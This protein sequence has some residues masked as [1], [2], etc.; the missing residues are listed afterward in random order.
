MLVRSARG[1]KILMLVSG[2]LFITVL[3]F[4][5]GLGFFI[6]TTVKA[7]NVSWVGGADLDW[8]TPAN[9]SSF[10]DLPTAL[11]DVRVSSAASLDVTTSGCGAGQVNFSTLTIGDGINANTLALSNGVIGSGGSIIVKNAASLIQA[12][13]AQHTVSGRLT[14]ESGGLLTHS[15]NTTDSG[16]HAVNFSM[17]ELDLQSGGSINVDGRGHE[18]GPATTNGYGA[19]GG[20]YNSS[21]QNG[22]GG[23]NAGDGGRE[24]SGVSGGSSTCD[25]TNPTTFGSGGAGSNLVA[26]GDGGGL[27][28][29]NISGTATTTGVITADGFNGGSGDADKDSG[30]GAGGTIKIV[31]AD[32]VG[33]PTSFTATGGNSGIGGGIADGGGGGGGCVYVQYTNTV[34]L[35]H[36][37]IRVFGGSANQNG[38]AGVLLLKKSDNSD[39]DL[40]SF[41]SGVVGAET[42]QVANSLSVNTL[43]VRGGAVYTV[44]S[45]NALTLLDST[46]FALGEGTSIVRIAGNSSFT[47]NNTFN[48]TSTTLELYNTATLNNSSS[49]DVG[50]G[51]NGRILLLYF[52]TSSAFNVNSL[53]VEDK[54]T[55]S[56]VRNY[57]AQT[58]I[59]NVNAS[60]ITVLS[61]GSVTADFG[62]YI[63]GGLGENGYGPGGGLFDSSG[64]D[65]AGAGHAGYGGATLNGV[66]GGSPYCTTSSPST[67]GSGGGGT[68]SISGRGGAGGGFIKLNSSGNLTIAGIILADGENGV[69]GGANIDGGG[70][71]GGAIKLAGANVD[72]SGGSLIA[73][74]GDSSNPTNEGGGGGGGCIHISYSGTYTST[75]VTTSTAGGSGAG[76]GT[77]GSFVVALANTAPS[78]TA[79]S[80]YQSGASAVTVT[81]TI[82]DVDL[83]ETSLVAE[84]SQDNVTWASSTISSVDEGG[85]GDGVVTSTGS[86]SGI[87]TGVDG[88]VGLTI[89]WDIWTDLSNIEDST[90]YFRLTP[91]DGVSYGTMV[92]STAFMIDTAAPS[93]PGSLSVNSTST[94]S[95]VLNFS[96]TSTDGNFSEYKIYYST[97]TPVTELATAFTSSTDVN[98]ASSTFGGATTTTISSLLANTLYYTNIYAYDTWG[99]GSSS[100]AETSFY[101]L[102]GNPTGLAHTEAGFTSGGF[103]VD[104]FNNDSGGSSGYYFD[105]INTMSEV[106]TS[107]GWQSG[108]NTWLAEGLSVNTRYAVRAN[109]RNGN[110]IPASTSSLVFYTD[111]NVPSGIT[112][113]ANST[114]QITVSWSG[115][116]SQYYVENT[117]AGTNSGW[118][119]ETSYAFSGLNSNT[120]Y[121]FRVKAKGLGGVETGWS[122]T[123]SATTQSGGGGGP[124]P[125]PNNPPPENPPPENPPPENPP[126]E[127]PPPENPPEQP[128]P[129]EPNPDEIPE[130]PE[131]PDQPEKPSKPPTE[132]TNP[133]EPG[134][135]GPTGEPE[136]PTGPDGAPSGPMND[137]GGPGGGSNFPDYFP[138]IVTEPVDKIINDLILIVDQLP[139]AIEFQT[140]MIKEVAAPVVKVVKK[141]AKQVQKVVDNPKVEKV[142]EVAVVPAVAIAGAANVAVGFQATQILA[143]LQHVFTQPLLLLRL[144]KRK[145]WGVVYNAL[146]KRPVDLAVIRLIDNKTNQ[147][148]RSQVTDMQGRYLITAESGEYRLEVDKVGFS[149]FS[150]YLQDK[151]EDAKFINLYHGGQFQIS[152]A[153]VVLNYNIP[154]DPVDEEKATALILSDYT[155]KITQNLI[156]LVGLSAS[157]LSFVISPKAWVGTLVLAHV[158]FYFLFYKFS[159]RKVADSSFGLVTEEMKGDALGRVVVR[160]FDSMYNKL[161][162]TAVTDR[163]G[164]YAVL[165]GPSKYYATYEKESFEKK[166]SDALD[167]SSEKTNGMGGLI[168][169]NEE[170]K[171]VDKPAELS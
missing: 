75:G 149:G 93:R 23:A 128:A 157:V 131:V 55:L 141:T 63:G 125:P 95:V 97:S 160:V 19:G 112:A 114:S 84:H 99:R 52:T 16:A 82:S 49:W 35:S 162:D 57:S 168:N 92:N 39:T 69:S 147:I 136:V 60:T 51:S 153:E 158:V 67:I 26:G 127:N 87:D 146:S 166:Q 150:K 22:S 33:T 154:I 76:L 111:T 123:V 65:G 89:L 106:V 15:Q 36:Q 122:S 102:V 34:S 148:I 80:P 138:P 134:Q 91:Y 40:Y 38:G 108:D 71:S 18:G 37:N 104:S 12:G 20:V 137:G 103:F 151:N 53:T 28:L 50:I 11:D 115:S 113:T 126:P 68:N 45:T 7:A 129:E 96:T 78:I 118:T 41:N 5:T 161:V 165:V 130:N 139:Q 31:A 155:K 14:I 121:S 81:T 109:Y 8:C 27:V 29:L 98:L 47:P 9:W 42:T 30:G 145:S 156:C 169:I 107:S 116:G 32:I 90:I 21:S 132:P 94:T 144:R 66:L 73:T 133:E 79:I 110:G 152:E 54:G 105:V 3:V 62:G 4:C 24:R 119:S 59:V 100:T 163:K 101:T 120:T 86:I 61:G 167:F 124:L 6:S 13:N 43:T 58:H 72:V 135:P 74:G 77:E 17:A 117:T 85:E 44:S 170:L 10:P 2:V 164:R 64:Q 143:I 140:Q 70:G 83:N 46:P 56:H 25:I 88:S 48:I 171:R 142:N 159:R 1:A